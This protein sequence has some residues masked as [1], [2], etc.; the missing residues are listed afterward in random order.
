MSHTMQYITSNYFSMNNW[1]KLFLKIWKL[2]EMSFNI[3]SRDD[4]CP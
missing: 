1:E 2:L 4:N 3:V